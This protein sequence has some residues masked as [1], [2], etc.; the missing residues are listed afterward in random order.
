MTAH[1]AATWNAHFT[2][3]KFDMTDAEFW[4]K[5]AEAAKRLRGDH[6]GPLPLPDPT[7]L[8]EWDGNMLM[9]GGVSLLWEYALGNGTSTADQTLTYLTNSRAAIGVGDSTT[10][11]AA[12]QNDLQAATN[13]LRK[14]M[15]TSYPTHSDGTSSGAKTFTFQ[16]IFSNSDANWHWQEIA[17]F[18]SATAAT[19]RMVDRVVQD[20]GTKTSSAV[21]T[22]N[23][24]VTIS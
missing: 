20:M 14:A 23:L 22:A 19:G 8:V 15:D 16:S 1:D 9:N 2:I 4:A 21:W 10:A 12:T 17:A 18:N 6:D 7:D 11:E 24:A 13:K 5:R 3:G